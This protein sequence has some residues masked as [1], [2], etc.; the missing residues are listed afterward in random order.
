MN[1]TKCINN[2][3]WG[4]TMDARITDVK[5]IYETNGFSTKATFGN[6][7]PTL[8]QKIKQELSQISGKVR[9]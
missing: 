2:K 6:N 9:R 5:E 3:V 7:R 8:I 1:Q 4:I